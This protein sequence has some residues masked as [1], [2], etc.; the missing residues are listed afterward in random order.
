MSH[1]H[2]CICVA[3]VI[4]RERCAIVPVKKMMCVHED[5]V[6]SGGNIVHSTSADIKV[7][8]LVQRRAFWNGFVMGSSP[9]DTKKSIPQERRCLIIKR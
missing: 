4:G 7:N 6:L 5:L 2:C 3:A 1:Y 9:N 8:H